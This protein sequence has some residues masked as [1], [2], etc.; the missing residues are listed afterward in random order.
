MTK[1]QYVTIDTRTSRWP[2]RLAML[3][4]CATI[5][6]IW[7]GGFVTTIGAG[8]AFETWPDSDGKNLFLYNFFF[9]SFDKLVEHSH[10]L[11]GA[12]IGMIT[13]AL[14]VSLWCADKR[15]WLGW[16]GTA[17][18]GLVIFQGVLGGMRVK[19]NDPQLAKLHGCVAPLFFALVVAIVVLTSRWWHTRQA[20]E[21]SSA[22][23]LQRLAVFTM[24]LAYLQLVLGAQLRHVATLSS[25]QFKMAVF[26]HLLL[27]AALVVQVFL[28]LGFCWRMH[29][30]SFSRPAA[31]LAG[32]VS[33]QLLLGG[34]TWLF[35]YGPP[36]W[37]RS[38]F[39]ETPFVAGWTNTAGAP[40]ASIVLT[41]HV[42]LG[43]LILG[44]SLFLSMRL[45]RGC[46]G[47]DIEKVAV[48]R[49]LK[50]VGVM[51]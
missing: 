44:T 40:F 29:D 1:S 35:K 45:L 15:R 42:A 6:L 13:I 9:A 30:R 19:A 28:L 3:L 26:F 10:R 14:C 27:A 25:G 20:V 50:V 36:G 47:T 16:L 17:A 41:T 31:L 37:L 2:H 23:R 12:L 22:G 46:R 7:V 51:V 5:M 48:P 49:H 24:I 4:L 43:S 21:H 33:L 38:M 34:T 32:L 18:L 8:M 11:F 39:A